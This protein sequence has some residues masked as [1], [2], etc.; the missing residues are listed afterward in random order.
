MSIKST[1]PF[2]VGNSHFS[3]L[4]LREINLQS[5][6]GLCGG[7]INIRL[8]PWGLEFHG[9]LSMSPGGKLSIAGCEL[10]WDN[11]S[12]PGLGV[13][14]LIREGCPFRLLHHSTHWS[15]LPPLNAPLSLVSHSL[16]PVLNSRQPFSSLVWKVG[17]IW[18]EREICSE[19]D[20]DL[21]PCS[22]IK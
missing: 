18:K 22:A 6:L 19:A 10:H 16:S 3:H 15:S 9:P 20:L 8:E 2:R 7:T 17:D 1:I 11:R 13:C 21:S 4:N 5:T 14:T 12:Q